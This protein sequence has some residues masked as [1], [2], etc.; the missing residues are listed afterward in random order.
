MF[1]LGLSVGLSQ[2]PSLGAVAHELDRIVLGT[3]PPLLVLGAGFAAV[4]LRYLIRHPLFLALV[5]LLAC[6]AVFVS[7]PGGRAIVA[8]ASQVPTGKIVSCLLDASGSPALLQPGEL[9]KVAAC[10]LPVADRKPT[11]AHN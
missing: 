10:K 9:A 8:R 4:L 7:L 3:P 6:A 5:C 2:L 11:P 1:E